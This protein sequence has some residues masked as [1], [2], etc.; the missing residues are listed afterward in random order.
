MSDNA[1]TFIMDTHVDIE[2][3]NITQTLSSR[4]KE[5]TTELA[6]WAYSTRDVQ[7]ARALKELGWTEPA[8]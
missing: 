5:Q 7:L 4:I 6:A 2:S 8:K 1:M 3:G